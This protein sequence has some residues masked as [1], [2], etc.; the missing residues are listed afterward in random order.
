MD[1]KRGML[2]N[3]S[4]LPEWH[5]FPVA[6]K[7]SQALAKPVSFINDANAAAFGEFWVGVGKSYQS[8]ALLT[9]GTG[10]GG[11]LISEGM[12]I[13]GV[14]S[15]GSEVGHVVVDCSPQ[16]R[17]CVWGGGR[18]QL[19]AYASASAVA[20]QA[21]K[22]IRDVRPTKMS[23]VARERDGLLTAKDVYEA[24]VQGD[25]VA[26]EIIDETAFYLGVGVTNVIHM[27]D[28][29]LVVLGGAMNFGGAKC[30]VGRRFLQ[31]VIDEFQARTFPNVFAGTRIDFASLG[32]DAG[33]IGAAGIAR[34]DFQAGK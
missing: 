16:A 14:N 29:G 17:L 1:L 27:I 10:V 7:L 6:D 15:F 32:G 3:P 21:N 24:A 18:G 5:N 34:Q 22:A 2:L 19:E 11:G 23:R 12:L 8:L 20:A 31:R 28:P 4:N 26:L 30:P 9:L 13:N 33:Y 25:D